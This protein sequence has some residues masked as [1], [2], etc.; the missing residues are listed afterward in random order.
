MSEKLP[1]GVCVVPLHGYH[2]ITPHTHTEITVAQALAATANGC[3]HYPCGH[4]T[5]SH[6]SVSDETAHP[7]CPHLPYPLISLCFLV[8]LPEQ[9]HKDM[10]AGATTTSFSSSW[11][12]AAED[13]FRRCVDRAAARI[14]PAVDPR[15]YL[16]HA[17]SPSS[18]H[19][20]RCD[21]AP[22]Y[23]V[24][25][26]RTTRQ[27]MSV[28]SCVSVSPPTV[29]P[30]CSVKRSQQAVGVRGVWYSLPCSPPMLISPRSYAL[31]RRGNALLLH[32]RRMCST[33]LLACNNA[34]PRCMRWRE[35]YVCV[36]PGQQRT[37]YYTP[38]AQSSP[39]VQANEPY[40]SACATEGGEEEEEQDWLWQRVREANRRSRPAPSVTAASDA[41]SE[42]SGG[43]VRTIATTITSSSSPHNPHESERKRGSGAVR[44]DG[45]SSPERMA[46]IAWNMARWVVECFINEA[47]WAAGPQTT[48]S[49]CGSGRYE[50]VLAA[51]AANSGHARRRS[52]WVHGDVRGV[53]LRAVVLGYTK[54]YAYAAVLN[55]DSTTSKNEKGEEYK[56]EP[57]QQLSDEMRSVS[58]CQD[59]NN[60]TA[61]TRYDVIARFPHPSWLRRVPH[62]AQRLLR[63]DNVDTR[64]RTRVD[65]EAADVCTDVV[66]HLD[67]A[68]RHDEVAGS[69][70][71][72]AR[73]VWV[74]LPASQ[75]H[76][77]TLCAH[78]VTCEAAASAE[79]ETYKEEK[80]K[81]VSVWLDEVTTV[82]KA[83]AQV[84]PDTLATL[85]A[86]IGASCA[87]YRKGAAAARDVLLGPVS[88]SSG[89]AQPTQALSDEAAMK[90]RVRLCAQRVLDALTSTCS[91]RFVPLSSGRGGG[92][93][94]SAALLSAAL[95]TCRGCACVRTGG[96]GG[97]LCGSS[98][99]GDVAV[100]CARAGADARELLC[101]V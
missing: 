55:T 89:R 10:A 90:Q 9:T 37:M 23:R 4:S 64:K 97:F 80:E 53:E 69:G 40:T 49:M 85:R 70:R 99:Q 91:L 19:W 59:S 13:V 65:E 60:T 36:L 48:S 3:T 84:E 7:T 100:Q 11:T 88:S 2:A 73:S 42:G 61:S 93:R 24:T 83:H 78:R 51:A 21:L 52:R 18:P 32:A 56:T 26:M 76:V 75:R 71:R 94:G 22:P 57:K 34:A 33:S 16:A 43:S 17:Y 63:D 8:P 95:V 68:L 62:A 77:V 72:P 27:E 15:Q 46:R 14:D 87:R 6:A 30:P 54:R 29:P 47:S 25:R 74:M 31:V 35:A 82:R 1:P 20:T 5:R 39:N 66:N 101:R 58:S 44:K 96:I 67:E 92:G 28:D 12:R 50:T 79:Y 45:G 41:A 86:L 38:R 98:S 81:S